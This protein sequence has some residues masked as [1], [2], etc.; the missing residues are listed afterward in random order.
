MRLSFLLALLITLSFISFAQ[1]KFL[2]DAAHA[3]TA[4]NADW[5]IS[6]NSG[7]T[8]IY[9]IPTPAQSGITSSTAESYWTGAI[10]SWGVALV[11]L[12]YYVETLPVGSSITYGTT[13]SQDLKNYNVFVIDEPNTV[14]TTA[15][16]TALINFVKNG[17]GLFMISD[18][19]VSDRNNDGWDSPMIWNDLFTNNGAVTNPF[20]LSVDLTNISQTSTNVLSGDSLISGPAGTVTGMQW[21]NGATI[22]VN[23]TANPSAKNIVW[24]TGSAQGLTNGMVAHAL[25]GKGRVAL[26]TD[27]S[28]ADDGTGASGNSLYVGWAY[29]GTGVNGSHAYLHL[30]GSIW[31]ANNTALPVELTSFATS[32]TNNNVSLKWNTATEVN[33]F[34]FEVERKQAGNVDKWQK[35]GT[36]MASG[37]SSSP[38]NY[39]FADNNIVTDKYNYRLKM[40]DNDGSFK[41]SNVVNASVVSPSRFELGNAYPNPWNPTTTIRY[42]VPS[43]SPVTI[44]V[45]DALGKEVATLVNEI[46]P[47]GSYQI[48]MNGNCLSSGIYFYQMTAGSFTET[49]KLIL[50]K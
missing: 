40:V 17:G 38:K 18:H 39:S 37:N 44:K 43:G 24:T 9:S 1:K 14:F 3:E 27:S 13:A 46:K 45:Y 35:V 29:T 19:T 26:V 33:S 50:L 2:F 20:G 30:N 22:T 34:A 42:N 25:F 8:T 28:P 31:L 15:E 49:K 11:K 41:Y 6:E 32:V 47:A 21:S 7:G 5:V 48:T 10:S 23:N 16:K 4:G 36:V 12:G